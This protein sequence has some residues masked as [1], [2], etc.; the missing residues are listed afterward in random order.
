MD[1]MD[2]AVVA[3][4]QKRRAALETARAVEVELLRYGVEV[5]DTPE[6]AM[7]ALKVQVPEE[8]A[9]FKPG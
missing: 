1:E 8:A 9:A 3:L 6:G 2:E 4:L 7:W 5:T